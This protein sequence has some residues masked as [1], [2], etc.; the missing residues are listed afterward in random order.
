MNVEW[1]FRRLLYLQVM[2]GLGALAVAERNPGFFLVA[3][4]LALLSWYVVEGPSGR[5]LG[6]WLINLGAIAALV[7]MIVELQW[8]DVAV[9]PA[10]GHLMAWLQVLLLYSRKKNEDYVLILALSLMQMLCASLLSVSM[11]YGAVLMAYSV[12]AVWTATAVALKVAGDG[13]HRAATQAAVQAVDAAPAS[14]ASAGLPRQF[15]YLMAG[16]AVAVLVVSAAVFTI[17]PRYERFG[18][19]DT[20]GRLM[21]RSSIGFNEEIR[22]GG[23]PPTPDS[24]QAVMTAAFTQDGLPL[25][26]NGQWWRL[27]GASL[28]EYDPVERRWSRGNGV[29]S[30]DSAFTVRGE[31]WL[32]QLPLKA[33]QVQAEITLR[34]PPDGRLFSMFPPV[35]VATNNPQRIRFNILDQEM[36]VLAGRQQP[37]TYRVLAPLTASAEPSLRYLPISGGGLSRRG[38]RQRWDPS[39]YALGWQVQPERLRG[40][41]AQ[42]LQRTGDEGLDPATARGDQ[43]AAALA[44]FLR[45]NYTYSLSS[46]PVVAQQDP[47]LSFLF[48]QR[49][50]HCE[51]FAAALAALR[52]AGDAG[53]RGD[54]LLRW[55][56]Q[57]HRRVLRGAGERC[58]RVVRN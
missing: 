7:L 16:V 14:G 40:L 4:A 10:S 51:L 49:Q 36:S 34:S 6:R 25:G 42:I 39:T 18:A 55:R 50:G 46:P 28:D 33:A 37:L 53:A 35:L 32:V 27:R 56:V 2:L 21:S 20:W 26:G 47:I 1:M 44:N 23:P 31:Q 54:G 15:H 12:A 5:P 45:S 43:I 19:A 17:S 48:V 3:G 38:G 57:P 58:A 52:G 22:L 9:L 11:L 24:Q 8:L 29:S 13:V 30:R 41:V